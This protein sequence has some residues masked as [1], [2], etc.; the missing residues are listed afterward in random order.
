MD[1]GA[2]LT[3]ARDNRVIGDWWGILSYRHLYAKHG[4]NAQ[5]VVDELAD[6]GVSLL[7]AG[8]GTLRKFPGW[9]GWMRNNLTVEYE[10]DNAVLF[11]LPKRDGAP[12]SPAAVR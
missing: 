12:H 6:N 4:P 9:D 10:D 11:A 7:A 8:R 1:A 2:L 5:G 3:Y